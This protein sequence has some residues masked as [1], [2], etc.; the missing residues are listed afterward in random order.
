MGRRREGRRGSGG[1]REGQGHG[2]RIVCRS[3]AQV[4]REDVEYVYYER[5]G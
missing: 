3:L 4:W 2:V 5:L 1:G